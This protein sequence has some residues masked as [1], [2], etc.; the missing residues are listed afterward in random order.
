MG[1]SAMDAAAAILLS[2]EM[3]LAEAWRTEP[4]GAHGHWAKRG[5]PVMHPAVEALSRP[6]LVPAT[7]AQL[8]PSHDPATDAIEG[9]HATMRQL[10]VVHQQALQAAHESGQDAARRAV[11]QA[12]KIHKEAERATA[13]EEGHKSRK[14]FLAMASALVGGAAVSYVEA[15]LG[16]PDV[17]TALSGISPALAEAAFEWKNRL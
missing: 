1:A 13:I 4:R 6:G 7:A 14:K 2:R 11:E 12:M 17:A 5:N 3:D 16:V 8:S 9:H 15:K 10:A